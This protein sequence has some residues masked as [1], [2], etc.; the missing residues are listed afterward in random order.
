MIPSTTITLSGELAKISG[1]LSG[2]DNKVKAM[3][4]DGPGEADIRTVFLLNFYSDMI[5]FAAAVLPGSAALSQIALYAYSLCGEYIPRAVEIVSGQTGV[6]VVN[7]GTNVS[8]FVNYQS[9]FV[10][11]DV[12]APIAAGD[13]SF[14]INIG[15]NRVWSNQSVTVSRDQA[16]LPQD[17]PGYVSYSAI[18]DTV[19]GLVT[20]TFTEAVQNSQLYIIAFNYLVILS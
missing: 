10:V 5:D 6:I 1:G 18:Y 11:G 17:K 12:G 19:S 2:A 4:S 8:S 7:P 15:K 14:T 13:T 20:I 3:L 9:D 16:I